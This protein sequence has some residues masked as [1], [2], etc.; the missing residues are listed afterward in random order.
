M[1]KSINQYFCSTKPS[2]DVSALNKR[3][4]EKGKKRQ[5]G[6]K[7]NRFR[8]LFLPLLLSFL[9]MQQNIPRVFNK[10]FAPLYRETKSAISWSWRQSQHWSSSS[11]INDQ[12]WGDELRKNDEENRILK[13]LRSSS[14][15]KI[16]CLSSASLTWLRKTLDLDLEESSSS[17]GRGSTGRRTKGRNERRIDEDKW[18]DRW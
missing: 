14:A 16:S 17:S 11:V 3:E 7:K 15:S 12:N 18:S 13:G 4:I 5:N 2:L 6:K 8:S 9:F 1:R 10:L